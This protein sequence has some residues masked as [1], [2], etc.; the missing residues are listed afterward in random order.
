MRNVVRGIHI[1]PARVH[2]DDDGLVSVDPRY[3]FYGAFPAFQACTHIIERHGNRVRSNGDLVRPRTEIRRGYFE[4]GPLPSIFVGVVPDAAT[5]GEW[6]ENV[7]RG[8]AQYLKHGHVPEGEIAKSGDIQEG[9]FVRA[10]I[11]IA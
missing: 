3:F 5:D 2:R 7:L 1:D 6:H 11:V 4:C 9:D 10:F 8:A